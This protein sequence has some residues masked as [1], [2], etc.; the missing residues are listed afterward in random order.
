MTSFV[1]WGVFASFALIVLG[2]V[3][4]MVWAERNDPQGE[5]QERR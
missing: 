4:W 5:D 3:A 2:Y 1:F